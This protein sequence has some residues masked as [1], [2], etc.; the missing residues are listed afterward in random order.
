MIRCL[1]LMVLAVGALRWDDSGRRMELQESWRAPSGP[2]QLNQLPPAVLRTLDGKR[3]TFRILLA[4]ASESIR[5]LT[6]YECLADDDVHCTVWLVGDVE[7]DESKP[8]LVR[9]KARL[10][11]HAATVIDGTAFEGFAE[12]RLTEATEIAPAP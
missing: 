8:L 11:Q 4:S 12:L 10:M 9:A 1:A 7:P 6:V 5:G 3:L 2:I